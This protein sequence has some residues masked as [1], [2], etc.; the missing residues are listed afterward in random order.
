MPGP[1]VS[2]GTPAL[3]YALEELG[4]SMVSQDLAVSSPLR[5]WVTA[6][7][8]QASLPTLVRTLREL[9]SVSLPRCS[10]KGLLLLPLLSLPL[11][12]SDHLTLLT[13]ESFSQVGRTLTFNWSSPRWI[14]KLLIQNIWFSFYASSDGMLTTSQGGPLHYEKAW[15]IRKFS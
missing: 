4:S 15:A 13:L 8:T 10:M 9:P 2:P 5:L 7:V 12:P 3:F 14:L 6:P 11:F 1:G